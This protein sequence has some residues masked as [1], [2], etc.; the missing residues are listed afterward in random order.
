VVPGR[1]RGF[2]AGAIQPGISIP[3][4]SGLSTSHPRPDRQP[5]QFAWN[6]QFKP[7]R[8]TISP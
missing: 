8:S 3:R 7:N 1:V 2:V 4:I 6:I 5:A